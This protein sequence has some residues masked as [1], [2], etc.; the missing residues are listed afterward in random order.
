VFVDESQALE[1]VDVA[2]VVKETEIA[3]VHP[4]I[5]LKTAPVQLKFILNNFGESI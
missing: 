1:H 5:W 2:L 4:A 3:C